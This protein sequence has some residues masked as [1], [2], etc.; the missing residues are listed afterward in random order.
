MRRRIFVSMVIA[1]TMT[2]AVLGMVGLA[3]AAP[4]G[5]NLFDALGKLFQPPPATDDP[6]AKSASAGG[7]TRAAVLP[8]GQGRRIALVIGN[9]NYQHPDNLPKLPNP[10]ND[11]EDIA[12]ALRGFDFEVIEYKNLTLE[13]MNRAVAEFGSRLGGSEAALFYFAGHGIQVKNQNYLM[14]VDAKIDSEAAVPYKGVNVNQILDEMDNGKS[15]A[16]IVMLD[17]CRNN[18]ISGKF[19]SGKSRGLASPDSVPGGTI[20]VY[21]TDPGNVAADGDGRNGLFTGGLLTAFKGKDLSLDD[22][23][24]VASAEVERASGNT[25]TPYVNGPKTLQRN[26]YFRVTVDQGRGEIEKTFWTSIEHSGDPA[27]FAAYLRKYPNGS[28]NTLAENRLKQLKAKP[29]EP[30]PAPVVAAPAEKPAPAKPTPPPVAIVQED[31]ESAFWN[32]VKTSG[33]REYLDAY[34]KQYPKGKYVGLVQIEVKKIDDREK[35]ERAKEEAERKAAAE[36]ARQE[37]A[38]AERAAWERAKAGD[39]FIAYAV[40]VDNYPKG[41]YVGLAQA[42][43]QKAQREAAD[44]D[45]QEA[46]RQGDE[47]ERELLAAERERLE[48]EKAAKELRPGKVFK[49]CADCPEMVVIPAGSFEMGSNSGDSDEKPVHTVRIGK[50]FA[51]AKTEVTQGQWRSVMG[52]NPSNFSS[53]GDDCPVEKVNWSDAEEYVRK[54]SQKT[55]KSYRLPSEAEWE[56]ACRAGGTHAYCGGESIDSV[57]WYGSNSGSKTHLVG[58][59]QANPWGLYDMSGNVWEWT[60]DCWNGSY[61]R[62]PSDGSAWTSGECG[63]RVL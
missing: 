25:Q 62:A 37:E 21:A 47:Q 11:V 57:A 7:A 40:Y 27:D 44:R 63:E 12:A 46:A 30:A 32:E 15:S 52:S 48:A 59:Q 31:P 14:P 20:I 4:E 28:C 35:A 54:L 39:S 41:R 42:A 10:T 34:L 49:D 29:A 55:G 60:E 17:A 9:G 50:A 56:Y 8:A 2:L 1:S 23:L 22:V 53:C 33:A 36:Q 26:F 18:P 51:L 6:G 3:H 13:D 45:R 16:N 43:Q 38:R 5:P 19:R 61:R 58:R 24:T